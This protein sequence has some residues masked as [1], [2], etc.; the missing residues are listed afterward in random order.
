MI[1]KIGFVAGDIWQYLDKQPE[2]VPFREIC[3]DIDEP[4][5]YLLMSLGWLAREGHVI[6]EE[7]KVP[8]RGPRDYK[9]TLREKE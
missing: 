3:R 6:L 8:R 4:R 2:G 5:D 7:V 1:T 9:V